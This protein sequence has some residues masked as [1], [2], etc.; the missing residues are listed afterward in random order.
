MSSHALH[1][2]TQC[3]YIHTTC[4]EL[5]EFTWCL[6]LPNDMRRVEPHVVSVNDMHL[7]LQMKWLIVLP[8]RRVIPLDCHEFLPRL[9]TSSH[10]A[11]HSYM[12]HTTLCRVMMLGQQ[13]LA[14]SSSEWYII[15]TNIL[16]F[17]LLVCVKI[18]NQ[19]YDLRN[20]LDLLS[21]VSTSKLRD[22]GTNCWGKNPYWPFY[23]PHEL[24]GPMPR[25]TT[26]GFNVTAHPRGFNVVA[27]FLGSASVDTE[28]ILHAT[29]SMSQAIPRVALLYGTPHSTGQVILRVGGLYSLG[30]TM[31]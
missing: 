31:G 29:H 18:V 24:A 2:V 15:P 3:H 9:C 7:S 27:H 30:H 5:H 25:H 16:A 21:K 11:K 28:L 4:R 1:S 14:S 22:W 20:R 12:L 19:S 6:Q 17:M 10:R 23:P 26:V 13:S 8:M